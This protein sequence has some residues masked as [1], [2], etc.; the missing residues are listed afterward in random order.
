MKRGEHAFQQIPGLQ[1]KKKS[2]S[3]TGIHP[4]QTRPST[5]CR[6]MSAKVHNTRD[7]TH[8]YYM[9]ACSPDTQQRATTWTANCH[10]ITTSTYKPRGTCA[11]PHHSLSVHTHPSRVDPHET[12]TI[13]NLFG[14]W[15]VVQ[16]Q[17]SYALLMTTSLLPLPLP[18]HP[19]PQAA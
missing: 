18:P 17:R 16:D 6:A 9:C 7:H 15:E 12:D 19:L 8:P 2:H 5:P 14:L 13:L 4:L 1:K 11:D 3:C 10:G